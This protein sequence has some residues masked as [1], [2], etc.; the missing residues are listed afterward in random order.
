MSMSSISPS[1]C[2]LKQTI[3]TRY[4]MNKVEKMIGQ[5]GVYTESKKDGDKG[6]FIV[7]GYKPLLEASYAGI[8]VKKM[9]EK[10]YITV[11]YSPDFGL[12]TY[13]KDRT[14][15]NIFFV[16]HQTKGKEPQVNTYYKGINVSRN[17][18]VDKENLEKFEKP[19]MDTIDKIIKKEDQIYIALGKFIPTLEDIK[20]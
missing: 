17:V 5:T 11:A 12:S 16:T 9:E 3:K 10:P 13:V 19:T 7:S 15:D 8:D 20:K 14:D 4:N 18:P 2:G 1:F 6:G